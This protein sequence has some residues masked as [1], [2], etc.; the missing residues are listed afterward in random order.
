MEVTICD[1][2]GFRIDLK[3]P[4]GHLTATQYMAEEIR[5]GSMDYHEKCA[6]EQ[7]ASFL[8]LRP[9]KQRSD[10]TC[11]ASEPPRSATAGQVVEGLIRRR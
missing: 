6:P 3:E 10:E 4:R 8:S 9:K 2:C 1:I 5:E 7:I 11:E